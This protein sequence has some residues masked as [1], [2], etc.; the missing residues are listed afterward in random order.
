MSKA[1]VLAIFL[2]EQ[3]ITIQKKAMLLLPFCLQIK[4][5]AKQKKYSLK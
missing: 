3:A 1:E 2:N 5:P 4:G